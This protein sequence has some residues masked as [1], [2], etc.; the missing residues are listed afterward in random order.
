MSLL[1]RLQSLGTYFYLAAI[2]ALKR[3]SGDMLRDAALALS[4]RAIRARNE[5]YDLKLAGV[6]TKA[7][8]EDLERAVTA[9]K[10]L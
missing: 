3:G 10:L 5:L 9:E 2:S 6:L 7:Q 1:L 4:K 8:V